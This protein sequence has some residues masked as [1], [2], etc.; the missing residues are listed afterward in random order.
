[1]AKQIEI[2]TQAQCEEAEI[3][4]KEYQLNDGAGLY[5][6]VRPSGSKAFNL[7]VY[8]GGKRY[9]H[10]I[11]T[12][13]EMSLKQARVLAK[14]KR[15]QI[16]KVPT[17]NALIAFSI[18]FKEVFS[19]WIGI[20]RKTTNEKTLNRWSYYN[21]AYFKDFENKKIR[22][23]NRA[24]IM[25]SLNDYIVEQ[26]LESFKKALGALNQVF[27][28]AIL[29]DY[30]ELNPAVAIKPKDLKQYFVKSKTKHFSYLKEIEEVRKL[31]EAILTSE[32]TPSL[33][34]LVM[35]QLY[36]VTRPG[37]ARL[38]QW[39]EIDLEKGIWTI[40][41][42]KMKAGE[43]HTI[44]LSKQVLEMLKILN[45]HS[46][47]QKDYI[48]KSLKLKE[49]SQNAVNVALKRLGYTSDIL[50]PHGLRATFA[51]IMNEKQDEHGLSDNIIQS[52]LAHK[53][54]N[55]IARAYNHATYERQ[56]AKLYQFWADLL[57][58]II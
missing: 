4:E 20:K 29:R 22:D 21:K 58:D 34:R 8:H 51:T 14:A 54:G 5:L 48:F 3:K 1:M 43:A 25:H 11:G 56:K 44:T 15:T 13:K 24:D 40:P 28:H 46:H 17:N 12:L 37:E 9:S 35:F 32:M 31:K 41:S 6:I 18:T 16:E 2:L 7:V 55:S 38:A 10:A 36:N 30:C 19:E 42:D 50:Q 57:G 49:F 39:C 53:I 33:K 26:K 47:T 45:T 23:V 52:C 27:S